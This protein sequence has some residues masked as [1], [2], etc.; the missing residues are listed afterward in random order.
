MF[1]FSMLPFQGGRDN[2]RSI[3]KSSEVYYNGMF[4]IGP[5]MPEELEFHCITKVIKPQTS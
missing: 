3:L 2:E 4:H 1:Y 5:N